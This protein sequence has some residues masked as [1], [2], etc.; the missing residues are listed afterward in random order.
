ML[1]AFT[2]GADHGFGQG[3]S[4][5]LYHMKAPIPK[6][7]QQ[8]GSRKSACFLNSRRVDDTDVDRSK[9]LFDEIVLPTTEYI[10]SKMATGAV[11]VACGVV[12]AEETFRQL[13]KALQASD[14][15][16]LERIEAHVAHGGVERAEGQS[17]TSGIVE[18]EAVRA[19]SLATV[20]FVALSV[21]IS[22]TLC[23]SITLF[24]PSPHHSLH[25]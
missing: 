7:G 8:E 24:L 1:L 12:V 3:A 9:E 25:D 20:P 15:W 19:V 13:S 4:V 17:F 22:L 2:A 18:A 16:Q 23:T 5:D 6:K 11:V 10:V 21:I 14:G